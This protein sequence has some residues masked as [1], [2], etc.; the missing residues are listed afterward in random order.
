MAVP[1]KGDLAPNMA[2][3][4]RPYTPGP[5]TEAE[6]EQFFKEG[7]VIKR[8][9]LGA[10]ELQPAID[11]IQ[12]LMTTVATKLQAAG[13]ISDICADVPFERRLI[14]LER[15]FPNASVLLHK[16]GI[17]PR[18]IADLWAGPTLLGAARQMLGDDVAGHP[19]WNLRTKTPANEQTTVPWHQD[20][21]YGE[22]AGGGRWGWG[23][24]W[25][26]AEA[27]GSCA[28]TRHAPRGVAHVVPAFSWRADVRLCSRL[29][30]KHSLPL[31][32]PPTHPPTHPLPRPLQRAPWWTRCSSR[33]GC[34]WWTRRARTGAW[35]LCGTGTA[36]AW[37]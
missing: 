34:R 36:R 11:S 27:L 9:L 31:P 35:R 14:E 25:G 18:G 12:A 17:L 24:G 5:F 26:F 8:G 21:A 37:R 32:H 2:A 4:Q 29:T 22:C 15:Q 10:A 3:W 20:V 7:Y 13:K 1:A 16:M 30:R 19:V 6:Y 23:R 33:R 28:C